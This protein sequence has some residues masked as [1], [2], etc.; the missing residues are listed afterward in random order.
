MHI[1]PW[2]MDPTSDQRSML[3]CY[4]EEVSHITECT[5]THDRLTLLPIDHRS[6]L[7][8]YTCPLPTDHRSMQHCYT[9]CKMVIVIR[10]VL[11]FTETVTVITSL[12]KSSLLKESPSSLLPESF[13]SVKLSQF[14]QYLSKYA[15]LSS[16]CFTT[17]NKEVWTW[18]D[19]W[20]P[21]RTSKYERP[22]TQE[23]NYLVYHCVSPYKTIS[24]CHVFHIR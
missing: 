1:Y 15:I 4:I 17:L 13:S 5:Y 19:D 14:L 10:S 8:H 11:M 20:P 7:H 22:F 12:L 16:S 9:P 6:M 2:L 21:W 3:H 18:K 24:W 23:G